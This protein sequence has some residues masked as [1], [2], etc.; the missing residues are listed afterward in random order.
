MRLTI[1]LD[2]DPESCIRLA[3]KVLHDVIDERGHAPENL[4]ASLDAELNQKQEGPKQSPPT[5][6]TEA[7]KQAEPPADPDNAR[8]AFDAAYI[9][10]KKAIGG[11]KARSWFRGRMGYEPTQVAADDLLAAATVVKTR[12][13]EE[14]ALGDAEPTPTAKAN[15][16]LP[17]PELMPAVEGYPEATEDDVRLVMGE[18]SNADAEHQNMVIYILNEMGAARGSEIPAHR[19]GEFCAKA[20]EVL[21]STFGQENDA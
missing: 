11:R 17:E 6:A 9:A 1:D 12:L 14:G 8:K 18:A 2:R 21:G 15:L 4:S 10:L 13:A 7:P 20:R 3:I 16:D 5:T 19:R